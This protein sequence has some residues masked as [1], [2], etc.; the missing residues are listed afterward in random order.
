MTALNR[1][2]LSRAISDPR[3]VDGLPSRSPMAGLD[4]RSLGFVDVLAQSVGAVAPSAAAATCPA[5]VA[6]RAGSGTLLA[7]LLAGVLMALVAYAI[8]QFTR[9]MAATGSLYTFAARGL[10]VRAGFATAAAMLVGYGFVAMFALLGAAYYTL[11]LL[12][13]TEAGVAGSEP[14]VI[15]LLLVFG[16]V[17]LLVLWRGIRISARVTLVIELA[18]IAAI[19]VLI[20]VLL[21]TVPPTAFSAVAVPRGVSGPELA[22]GTT[23]AIT[24][25]VGF[26]SAATLGVEA[27]R[28]FATVPRTIRWTVIAAGGLYLL[29]AYTQLAG[30]DA[31]GGSLASSSSPVNDLA[32]RAGVGWIGLLLDAALTCSFIACALASTTALGR[33]LFS[34]GREGIAPQALGRTHRRFRTP[35]IALAWGV[36]VEVAVPAALVLFGMDPWQ[37]MGI[38]VVCAAAGYMTA[39]ALVCAATPFFLRRIGEFTVGP[40]V[41]AGVAAT[42][43]VAALGLDIW[44]EVSGPRWLAVFILAVAAVGA[45]LAYAVCRRTRTQ[46]LARI[47]LYDEPTPKDVLGGAP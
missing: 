44:L 26:E 36:A 28:P 42:G 7:F 38:V 13:R 8:N 14:L 37:A 29:S 4:R 9:R 27:R 21:A 20:G 40:A 10:G 2:A 3:P 5:L 47:G 32:S 45:L 11:T 35:H 18:S 39:Y 46:A 24:A 12:R 34:L 19:L 23:V 41:A 43:L 25:F 6:A 1:T 15:V 30:F 17:C 16:G 31:F 33:V 22:A